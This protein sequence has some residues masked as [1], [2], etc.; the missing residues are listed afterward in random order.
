MA[1]NKII[2]ITLYLSLQPC[3]CTYLGYPRIYFAGQHRAHPSTRNNDRCDFRMDEEVSAEWGKNGTQEFELFNTIVTSVVYENGS[4]STNDPIVG[5]GNLQRPFANFV[6]LDV[7][8]QT[9]LTI[10]GLQF[11]ITWNES[12][13]EDAYFPWRMDKEHHDTEPMDSTEVL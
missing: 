12:N 10:Y 1:E 5:H 9:H 13:P 3:S 7:D 6:D 8:V 11:G 4:N 2:I